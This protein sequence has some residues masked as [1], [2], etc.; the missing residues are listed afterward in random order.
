MII[1]NLL[2]LKLSGVFVALH[3]FLGITLQHDIYK[4]SC[5]LN[6]K[7]QELP[8]GNVISR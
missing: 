4:K 7:L 6:S 8:V 3:G 1:E 2:V 5:F